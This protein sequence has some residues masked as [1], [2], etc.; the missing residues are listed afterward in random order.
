MKNQSL[1]SFLLLWMLVCV[2]P[3]ETKS[4]LVVDPGSNIG[5]TPLEF[6]QTYLV[7]TGVAVSNAKYNGST[8]P[9]N[10]TNRIPLNSRD[11]IGSFTNTGNAATQ[12]GING[13][14]LLS[15]GFVTKAVA[16]LNPNDDMWG[17]NQPSETDPDL[18]ILAG[19]TIND[20]SILEFDFVPQTDVVTFR[21]VFGSI[22]FDGF[23]GSIND[24]FG[25]FLSGPGIAGG[26]GF[27]NDA[28]NIAL[29]PNSTNYVTIFSICA[30]D[31]GNLGNG[32]YSWWNLKKDYFSY[33][34]LT[35]VFSATYTVVCNETYHMKFAIGDASDGV[36][37]S[38]VFLEQN[39]FSSNTV[40]SSTS[41]SNPL[42]GDL[43]VEGCSNASLVFSV[44][45]PL[46]T[47]LNIDLAIH[48]S[49]T[50]TQ[51]DILP[52]PFPLH[53]TILPGQLQSTPIEIVPIPDALP[54]S[55]EN[56]V[57]KG[58]TIT[59]GISN[60]VTTELL[61][62]DYNNMS[63]TLD[64]VVICNGSSATLTPQITGGQ[65]ILPDDVYIYLWST[66]DTTASIVVSPPAGHHQYS[67]TVT[68]ACGQSAIKEVSVDVG[69]TPEAAG[70]IT[71]SG[72]ICTP[73]NAL[74]YSVPVITGTDS[75]IWT[76]PAGATIISGNNTN[77]IMVDFGITASSGTLSVKGHSAVCGDGTP[78]N[79]SLIINPSVP[80]AGPISGPAVVCQGPAEVIFSISPLSNT[81][82]Y[83]WIVPSGVTILNGA[84]TNQITCLFTPTAI[85]GNFSVR[86]YNN[87]CYF[88]TS[89]IKPV[90]VNPLPAP[91]GTI[92]GP[93]V[94]CQGTAQFVFSIDPLANATSYTWTVPSG[95]TITNGANTNQI[96]CIFTPTAISGNF[97]VSGYNIQCNHGESASKPVVVNPMPAPAG[98]I[99]GPITVCQGT[100]TVTYSIAPLANATSYDWIVPQGVTIVNGGT[101]NQISCIFTS[102][103]VSGDF[104]VRGYNALCNFGTPSVKPVVVNPLPSAPGIITSLN[105]SDICSP[106][107]GAAY[108]VNPISNALIYNWAYSG[109]GV[110]L[111]NHNASL[112]IDFSTNATAGVLTVTGENGCGA[113]P[114]SDSYTI[115]VHPKPIV[116]FLICNDLKTTK[117]GRPIVLKGGRPAGSGGSYH[118]TGVA[119]QNPGV[120]VFDPAGNS[121]VGGGTVN[122]VGHTITYRYTNVFNCFD[123]KS[124]VITVFA[125][126]AGDPC[127]GTV[128]DYRDNQQYPT[129]LSAPLP[130][131]QC[132]TAANLNYG[133]YTDKL[134]SQTE[135][136]IIEKYCKNNIAA[137]CDLSGGFYQWGELMQYQEIAGFQDICMPGWHVATVAEWE[138][139]IA[140]YAG[141][142]NAGSALKDVI[143][144]DGFHGLLEGILYNNNTW[145]FTT[146]SPVGTMFWTSE[147]IS[148]SHA[149]ARG[150]NVFNPSVSLAPSS[151]GNAY[152]VRC[153]RN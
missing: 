94:V 85:S 21:Y 57:I 22:E 18:V 74:A 118:G 80:D 13:G 17:N 107:Q 5:M 91:A 39:S 89:S 4:Q 93:D 121:V 25:L 45:Q 78:S 84:G 116:D 92:S 119:Q 7:G 64:N 73:A 143:N 34:R 77:A 53:A 32:V 48:S 42:T 110:T 2:F 136:C 108:Q 140:G 150:I 75:Y 44:P 109:N 100:N 98:T 37:D 101:T 55:I 103:A 141:N 113:G 51:A 24:A 82:S 60:V 146:G 131:P 147:A 71:G 43:L 54:E 63:I 138:N 30:A 102:S 117:N 14:V 115:S 99:S 139:L 104:S 36:L 129:F 96:T 58:T 49:G 124:A 16:G 66:A 126:N 90:V 145:A 9:L 88:G 10:S 28:V 130:T 120:F 20:K 59:C 33:N 148:G 153:V 65:H 35:Y 23:C 38:G 86:G 41:F 128:K 137:Q 11:E 70:P 152:N 81:T 105:G 114:V 122:G 97:T 40:T 56:L 76:L 95:V 79:L 29:L 134:N 27:T 52:N 1:F 46:T 125:S 31:Q 12:L 149:T 72:I 8:D 135:N 68:D 127:P 133:N 61:I 142:G 62:K 106:Q 15:T 83:E 47:S 69:T 50:A 26:L 144:T 132:W 87:E 151:R 112:L 19:T 123:E 111:N 3:L 67:V 6:V